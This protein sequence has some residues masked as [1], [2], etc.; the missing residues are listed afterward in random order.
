M[1]LPLLCKWKAIHILLPGRILFQNTYLHWTN[2][3]MPYSWWVQ[4]NCGSQ[5]VLVGFA[6]IKTLHAISQN[7]I[8]ENYQIHAASKLSLSVKTLGALYNCFLLG[9][10]SRRWVF[11]ASKLGHE[12]RRN[13]CEPRLVV[14]PTE[15]PNIGLLNI[16]S[17]GISSLGFAGHRRLGTRRWTSKWLRDSQ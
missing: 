6:Y 2:V 3:F 8:F 10:K 4:H 12:S 15:R 9:R 17:K 1:R 14:K 13:R 11:T 5:A 7:A 16:R